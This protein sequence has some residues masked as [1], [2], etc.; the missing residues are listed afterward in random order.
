MIT[1]KYYQYSNQQIVIDKKSAASIAISL[2]L[3]TP[4]LISISISVSR[5]WTVHHGYNSIDFSVDTF[6]LMGF[7]EIF[8]FGRYEMNQGYT[9][10]QFVTGFAASCGQIAGTC[11]MIYASTYGLAGPSS[12]MI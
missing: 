12:A 6:M 9:L 1:Q 7:I 2:G 5:Y 8:M 10:I 3:L 11:L 4:F